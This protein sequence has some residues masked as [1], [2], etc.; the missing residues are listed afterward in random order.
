MQDYEVHP[1]M[2]VAALS[3]Q[4]EHCVS[5]PANSQSTAGSVSIDECICN[6]N[7]YADCD[8][9]I[10]L[11]PLNDK[12]TASSTHSHCQDSSYANGIGWCSSSAGTGPTVYVTIDL[13]FEYTV[14]GVLVAKRH[15]AAQ[16][17]TSV[18]V[19]VSTDGST[20]VQVDGGA[21]YATR[22]ANNNKLSPGLYFQHPVTVIS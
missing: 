6:S 2:K 16:Y 1:S 9:L 12:R 18:S 22:I 8:S 14:L 10:V 20:F 13:S 5:C 11:D 21:T 15:N 7:Y 19:D 3:C 17:A 4:P